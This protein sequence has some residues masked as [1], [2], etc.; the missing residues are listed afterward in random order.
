MSS[1]HLKLT[2]PNQFVMERSL[3]VRRTTGSSLA[4]Y[5]F[6]LEMIASEKCEKKMGSFALLSLLMPQKGSRLGHGPLLPPGLSGESI[7]CA[8]YK[9]GRKI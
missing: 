7:L 9:V 6:H 3:Q 1:E 5:C 2:S 8:L 4:P